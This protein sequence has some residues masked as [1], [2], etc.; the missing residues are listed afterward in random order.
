MGKIFA[1]MSGK[2]GVGKST[3]AAGLAEY[4]ARQ[5]KSTV[6]VDGDTGLRCA[7]LMLNV[8]DQ[9]LY[10][11]GDVV[12]K[13]CTLEQALVRPAE[14][15]TLSLLAAP[16]LM[17]PSDLSAKEMGRLI[18]RLSDLFDILILDAPAGVGR[19]LKNLLGAA[20]EPVIVATPD[21]ISVRDA[22]KLGA[23]LDARQEPRPSV[24]FNRVNP[25]LVRRGEMTPP[26]ALAQAL[27][28]PLMGVIP[29]SGAVYR[30]LLKHQTVMKCG[31]EQLVHAIAAL[32]KRLIG[33]E[34]QLPEYRPS[35]VLRFFRRGGEMP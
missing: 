20:A 23:L 8:Q 29:E 27:D 3:I 22:E 14:I 7:D 17:K 24:V 25:A 10:D 21:D 32:A 30:A 35:A 18:T 15:H 12:N 6:L 33:Q 2:G 9:V 1:I 4:Y 13:N 26:Q 5:G 19:G 28:M 16:Q 11:L 34:A 31:D